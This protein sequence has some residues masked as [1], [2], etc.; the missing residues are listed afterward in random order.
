[1]ADPFGIVH[2]PAGRCCGEPSR[3][4]SDTDPFAGMLHRIATSHH[5]AEPH[6]SWPKCQWLPCCTLPRLQL[7]LPRSTNKILADKSHEAL[8][9]KSHR[10]SLAKQAS[11][12]MH[13][14]PA[15]WGRKQDLRFYAGT[16]T[17]A[18]LRARTAEALLRR[19][20]WTQ[21]PQ[22][23]RCH[24]CRKSLRKAGKGSVH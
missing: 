5:S 16:T 12:A 3:R 22:I 14:H 21:Q 20:M 19:P 6:L 18:L 23:A 13:S 4:G 7:G 8:I 10:H 17:A 1:M 15:W 11:H 2:N 24:V 9:N